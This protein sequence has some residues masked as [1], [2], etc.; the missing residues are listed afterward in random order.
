MSTVHSYT[1]DQKVVDNMHSD[2]RRV[3]AATINIILISTGTA[4]VLP[5]KSLD[6]VA[7]RVSTIK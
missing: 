4:I 2:L 1:N 3:C 7:L 6:D 5:S